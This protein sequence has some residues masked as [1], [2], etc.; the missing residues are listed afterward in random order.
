MAI[1]ARHATAGARTGRVKEWGQDTEM[2]RAAR[3]LLVVAQ[4]SLV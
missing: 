2:V 4:P 3:R 1:D